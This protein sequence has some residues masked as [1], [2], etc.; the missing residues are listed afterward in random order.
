M[1]LLPDVR[2]V[3]PRLATGAF[4]LNAGL[5]MLKADQ[6]TAEGVHGMACTAY[7]FLQRI[8]AERFTRLLACAEV[9]VG[10]ALLA[11]FVPTRLAGLALT[12]FSGGLV[13]MYLRT[14]GMHEPGSPRPTQEGLPLA[15]DVW[16][17]GTGLGLLAAPGRRRRA[18]RG[19]RCRPGHHHY[20]HKAARR[21][22]RCRCW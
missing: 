12:G 21:H 16:M 6:G 11:P 17:L 13:G 19:H 20:G 10:G 22:V 5:T 18:A 4:I 8:P 1:V 3:A 14:P 2:D 7:P 9:A 15:K